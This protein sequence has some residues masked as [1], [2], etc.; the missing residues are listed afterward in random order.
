MFRRT[1]A[2]A[3][4]IAFW[5]STTIL[6]AQ[7]ATPTP[8]AVR[9]TVSMNADGTRTTYEFDPPQRRAVATTTTK[10]GKLV[11]RIRYVLDEAG[12]FAS[13]EVYGPD[14]KLRFKTLYKYDD[15]GKLTQE[16][17]LGPEDAVRNKIVY[18]H[19]KI[20]RQTGY[21]VYD[22]TGKLIRRTQG[23]APRVTTPPNKRK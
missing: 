23:A 16:T 1:I 14:E 9:V 15:A 11:G 13:G 6:R 7:L 20:G 21:S 3:V 12:R 8:D 19:D 18:A 22:A 5:T 2:A 17:Q 4:V 10:E